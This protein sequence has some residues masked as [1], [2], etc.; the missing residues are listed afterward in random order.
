MRALPNSGLGIYRS[1]PKAGTMAE[2]SNWTRSEDGFRKEGLPM[3]MSKGGMN[4]VQLGGQHALLIE[5]PRD[6]LRRAL[7]G[8]RTYYAVGIEAVGRA[9][10][11]LVSIP[12]SLGRFRLSS[13]G[14]EEKREKA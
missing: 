8:R 6:P 12:G 9:G 13:R 1:V 5:Y 3:G 10:D 11:V 14:G 2:R 4:L 7:G